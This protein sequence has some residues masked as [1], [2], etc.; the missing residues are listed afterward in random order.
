MQ[1]LSPRNLG[2]MKAF[3]EAWPEESIL[4]VAL[5]KIAWYHNLTLLEKVKSSGERLWYAEQ[6]VANG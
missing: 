5:A 6:T 1:G 3:A 4:Q 2:S